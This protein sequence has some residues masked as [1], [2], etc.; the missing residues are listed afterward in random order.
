MLTFTNVC[1]IIYL[2]KA[3][4][5]NFFDKYIYED[6]ENSQIVTTYE[7]KSA[8]IGFEENIVTI[9]GSKKRIYAHAIKKGDII[10]LPISE[11]SD[12]YNIEISNIEETKVI[13]MDSLDREQKRAIVTSNV[14]V[15]SSTNF[16]AKTVDRVKKGETVIVVSS[17]DDYSRIRTEDGK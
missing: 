7:K 15:K 14:S 1:D 6:K 10:Y 9:N 3:D 4:I 2:S 11:M 12:V 5:S 16:I 17:K 8:A 13:T